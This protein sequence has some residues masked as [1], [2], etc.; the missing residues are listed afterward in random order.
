MRS[1]TNSSGERITVTEE[2]LKTAV[3][4]KKELQ[5]SSPSRKAP[6]RMIVKM[7]EQ[8]G[9][10]DADTNEAYRQMIK[11]YQK[12]VGE[13]PTAPTYAEMVSENKLSSIREMVGDLAQ[14]KYE[15]QQV[16]RELNKVKR[17]TSAMIF[18]ADSI[19]KSFE[20]YDYSQHQ[21][22]PDRFNKLKG[23]GG[24]L[25]VVITDIHIGALVKNKMNTYDLE[26]AKRRLNDYLA[27][28]FEYAE[29]NN[30]DEV[31]IAVLG[32]VIEH[33]YMHNLAYTSEFTLSEQAVLA[34]DLILKFALAVNEKYPVRISA[35]AGNHD[36]FNSDKNKSLSGD[37]AVKAVNQTIR[38]FIEHAGEKAQGLRFEQAEDYGHTI[39]AQGKYIKMVHGD[40]DAI[41]DKN[42]IGKH[43]S[44][45]EKPY[46][47]VIMGH[48]HHHT[49]REVG[50][51]KYIVSFGSL[52]GVDDYGIEKRLISQ[53]SQG[54]VHVRRDG[55]MSVHHIPLV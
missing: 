26:V 13:L 32:D 42:L 21:L 31:Y 50:W 14:E 8:E 54:F 46:S 4:I 9:F 29:Q 47:M 12:S 41:G 33:P 53:P 40:L 11:S 51:K 20:N 19:S 35:I 25:I 22:K 23:G 45:D 1:Y 48:Y 17:E 7:M 39:H 16:Y 37:H 27:E 55:E 18:V 6:M 52:K 3:A 24:T 5:K 44:N 2:H 15:A 10:Y 36:R 43:S 28:V 38:N 30:I 34:S 49:V